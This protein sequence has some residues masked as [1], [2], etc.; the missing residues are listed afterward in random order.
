MGERRIGRGVRQGT[1]CWLPAA[2][3][4]GCW[5]RRPRAPSRRP[6]RC[7]PRTWT[8]SRR[9]TRTAAARGRRASRRPVRPAPAARAARSALRPAGRCRRRAVAARRRRPPHRRDPRRRPGLVAAGRRATTPRSSPSWPGAAALRG[10]RRVG[11]RRVGAA[12]PS[13]DARPGPA[14]AA[15]GAVPAARRSAAAPGAGFAGDAGA[16]A[17]HLRAGV[18]A[19]RCAPPPPR[20]RHA[21]PD[22]RPGAALDDARMGEALVGNVVFDARTEPSPEDTLRLL[23]RLDGAAGFV[24]GGPSL[25]RGFLRLDRQGERWLGGYPPATARPGPA[26]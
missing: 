18:Q 4:A 24:R 23:P 5:P 2:A 12:T 19:D 11:R 17:G 13:A 10:A 14:R 21:R 20:R 7:S 9:P 6:R 1:A 26:R 22:G 3:C 8:R 16:L 15:G 25:T